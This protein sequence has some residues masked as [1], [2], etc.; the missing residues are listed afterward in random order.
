MMTFYGQYM[1]FAFNKKINMYYPFGI[2]SMIITE[3]IKPKTQRHKS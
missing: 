3:L 1:M 2:I